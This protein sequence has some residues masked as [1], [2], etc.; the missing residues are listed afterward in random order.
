MRP[1]RLREARHGLGQNAARAG[2][3]E[4]PLRPARFAAIPE[5]A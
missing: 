4:L 2:Q 5:P 3:T 1:P